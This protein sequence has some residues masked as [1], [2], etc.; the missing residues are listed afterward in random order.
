MTEQESD[1]E[2]LRKQRDFYKRRIDELAGANLRLDF[3]GSGLRHELKQKRQGFALLSELQQTIGANKEISAIFEI[4]IQ[5]INTTLGMDRTVVLVQGQNEDCYTPSQWFGFHAVATEAFSRLSIRFPPE[6]RTGAGL[7]VVN[8]AT[9]PTALIEEIRQAFDLPYFVCS[10]V[11][12]EDA[13]IGLLLSGRLK[14]AQPLYPPLDQGD[15]DTFQAITGLISAC[16][17]NLRVGVLEETD[18]LKTE[19]FA[20]ISHEFRTPITLTLGPLEG[21]LTGRYGEASDTIRD[22]VQV[23]QRNQERLLGLVNQILDLAKLEAGGMP[24]KASP[25]P[26]MNRYVEERVSQF[27]STAEKLEIE[28][29]V[30]LDP[31]V[32]G[33]DL[34][35]DRETF[36]K[37]LLNLMSNAHKFTK[38]GYV[39]VSTAIDGDSFCLTVTDT[40]VGIKADQ[41]PHIF[42]RFRQADG[43]V[44]REFGG[45]GLGLAWVKEIAKLHGGDVTVHSQ[46]GKGSSFRVSIPL[47]KAHLDPASVVEFTDEDLSTLSS[48]YKVLIL[49]EEGTDREGVDHL[50][51]KTEAAFDK[52]K[53]TILYAEDNSDLRNYIRDLLSKDYNVFLAVDGRDGMEK[54]GK[55]KPDL[56]LTDH[57]MPQM[58]GRDLLHA[59]RGD[60]ELCSIPVIF[61]TARAGSEARIE[62]LDAGA[63]DYIA[64]PFDEA[65]LIVRIR[66]VLHG[67]AQERELAELNH[68]LVV[69]RLKRF[70][71]P[72]LA[73]LILSSGGDKLLESH[74]R[75]ISVVFCDLRGFTAFSETTE[76]EEVMEVLQEYHAAMGTLIFSFE[77][78]LERFAGDGI[79]VYF[80]DPIPCTDPAARAVQMAL[81]M[82]ERVTELNQEWR[83]R[84]YHLDFGVGI[85]L[86]YAT[87]GKI[88]F[89]GRFDYAAIGS[90]TNLASRL[91]DEA[92]GGQILISQR[93]HAAVAELVHAEPIGELPL[94]GLHQPVPAFNVVGLKNMEV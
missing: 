87:L 5:A 42:D 24:L 60:P 11:M 1:L 63:D 19:F 14:Q 85:T 18:R 4:A 44:S 25:M 47:G 83:K 55:Y 36:D 21:I 2:S 30:S 84:G 50:N 82:R 80:N 16:V 10:P 88:G 48:S 89:E 90:V 86:G 46:Y 78:T 69:G 74:R 32:R 71:S 8:K 91:C 33:A 41:L 64:K 7:L 9:E 13:P 66:N 62:S 34:F 58:S 31:R 72:Q 79:M 3:T 26:D 6:F 17:G 20:N 70:V 49:S 45:T 61:L 12:V 37:L 23:M 22:Q 54:A 65:E 81:A 57:M 92:Q 76:P 15:A 53:Q 27:R 59:I 39:E 94:K 67:R 38:E 68:A 28:L 51:Q 43:G 75:Q 52:A 73:D 77:A 35:I 29:R 56:V 93:V 40:G